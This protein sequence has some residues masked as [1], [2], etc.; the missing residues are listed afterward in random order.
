MKNSDYLAKRDKV[1]AK[2]DELCK[3]RYEMKK[4]WLGEVRSLSKDIADESI[5]RRWPNILAHR[6]DYDDAIN[7]VEDWL[8]KEVEQ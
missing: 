6:K 2:Y 3:H 4:K 8:L 5:E 7:K 1:K